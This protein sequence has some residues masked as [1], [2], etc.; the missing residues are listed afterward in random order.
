[1]AERAHTPLKELCG[2][3]V[4]DG[5]PEELF[6]L[7]EIVGRGAYGA[8]WKAHDRRTA[9]TVALKLIP[10]G[11]RDEGLEAV[12][13]EICIL[14]EC[15]HPN[16]VEFR[17]TYFSDGNLWILMEYCGGKSVSDIMTDLQRPLPEAAIAVICREALQA[18]AYLHERLKIH[19][20]VKC[21][22]VLLT[23]QG[24]V[25]LADFG[26]SAQLMH[27]FSS[28][29]SF[30][31][32][33]Y[34]MAPEVMREQFYNGRADIWS[35]GICCIEMAEMNP[36]V[37]NQHPFLWVREMQAKGAPTF[38]AP[39]K[40][41]V[42]F[43]DFT[44]ACLTVDPGQ[45]PPAEALLQHVFLQQAG[46]TEQL[47]PL[48][49]DVLAARDQLE[50]ARL[51]RSR[52][53]DEEFGESGSDSDNYSD[54]GRLSISGPAVKDV[55]ALVQ[56]APKQSMVDGA[57]EGPAQ[58]SSALPSTTPPTSPPPASDG[59]APLFRIASQYTFPHPSAIS[60]ST[61]DAVPELTL[62]AMQAL[63][64]QSEATVLP[65]LS[66]DGLPA[67]AVATSLGTQPLDARALARMLLDEEPL[68]DSVMESRRCMSDDVS[69]GDEED[70]WLIHLR[71][72]PSLFNAVK[73]YDHTLR[74][75]TDLSH[76]ILSDR[77]WHAAQTMASDLSSTLGRVFQL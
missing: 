31:G 61:S 37:V 56:E 20:D 46:P 69:E 40:W 64:T 27:A 62:Q 59:E 28:R 35:L 3:D 65:F 60:A 15:H 71:M 18:L 39:E 45:R 58:P 51:Q 48:V 13:R 50:V 55:K 42:S 24:H 19:R 6:E 34:W 72:T 30:V 23:E 11:G 36:P 32:T 43:R 77:Q 66:L 68:S 33:S 73:C 7:V 38:S 47:V 76:C 29:N 67:Q 16:I 4:S 5:D 74:L 44:A 2:I 12:R 53:M 54:S 1:M 21:S 8:V 57:A 9:G 41:S 49:R 22:N 26:V 10:C 25:K 75:C 70:Q 52:E 63:L 14:R 17:G